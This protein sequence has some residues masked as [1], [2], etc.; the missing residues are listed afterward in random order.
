MDVVSHTVVELLATTTNRPSGVIAAGR[1]I[2]SVTVVESSR[3][4]P[5]SISRQRRLTAELDEFKARSLAQLKNNTYLPFVLMIGEYESPFPGP[6]PLLLMLTRVVVPARR[7]RRNK[8]DLLFVS[9]LTR[10]DARLVNA[11]Y[12]PSG[13]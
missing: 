5:D 4:T 10:S 1:P 7:S 12:R 13:V 3:V 11:T 6:V 9:P 2:G 8:S